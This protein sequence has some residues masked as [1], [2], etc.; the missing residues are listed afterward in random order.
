MAWSS[1]SGTL[2]CRG[3]CRGL[4]DAERCILDAFRLRHLEGEE[5]AFKA[6]RRWLG[7]LR[8]ALRVLL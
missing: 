7:S 1:G 6:L 8:A 5:M 2:P 3:V 4:Y